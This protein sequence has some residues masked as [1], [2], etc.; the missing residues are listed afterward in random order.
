MLAAGTVNRI[1]ATAIA[2][3]LI[4]ALVPLRLAVRWRNAF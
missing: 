4:T 3:C 2:A 1:L